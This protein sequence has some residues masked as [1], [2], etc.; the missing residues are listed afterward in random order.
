MLINGKRV[1][2][3][4]RDAFL[5][6]FGGMYTLL[7]WYIVTLP[8]PQ[9]AQVKEYDLYYSFFGTLFWGWAWIVGGVIAMITG[10]L[11]RYDWIG[12]AAACFVPC[13]WATYSFLETWRHPE[14]KPWA[15]GIIYLCLSI[16][17]WLVA[18]MHNPRERPGLRPPRK[19]RVWWKRGRP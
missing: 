5:I 6:L 13:I 1:K 7:G 10:I 15:T 19:Q 12:F 18:G 8:P 9:L 14:T 2:V 16:A 4:R 17:S 11:Y 3:S